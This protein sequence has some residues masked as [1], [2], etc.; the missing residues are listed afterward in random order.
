MAAKTKKPGI[1]LPLSGQS[2]F[3]V[4]RGEFRES[5]T[6]D[7]DDAL[8]LNAF[9]RARKEILDMIESVDASD[10]EAAIETY[11][12]VWS[13]L[14][15]AVDMILGAGACERIFGGSQAV[16]GGLSLLTS[17]AEKVG[18]AYDAMFGADKQT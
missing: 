5:F 7:F 4:R 18:P 14:E 11:A 13:S 1:D 2:T 15:P 8:K 10:A 17:L 12:A 9:L 6:V 3:E 16:Y